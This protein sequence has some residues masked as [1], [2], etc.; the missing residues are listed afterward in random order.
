MESDKTISDRMGVL[1]AGADR[2][3]GVGSGGEGPLRTRC[4]FNLIV[5]APNKCYITH[6][7]R[8]AW[9]LVWCQ[10]VPQSVGGPGHISVCGNIWTTSPLRTGSSPTSRSEADTGLRMTGTFTLS[11][12]W[13]TRVEPEISIK[14][15]LDEIAEK[16]FRERKLC[17]SL[18]S[19]GIF[20]F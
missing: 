14:E 2:A 11:F 13:V 1:E 6:T 12:G 18:A 16:I 8:P 20:D 15:I 5:F 7:S 4:T 17:G 3:A 9:R 19:S 10:G